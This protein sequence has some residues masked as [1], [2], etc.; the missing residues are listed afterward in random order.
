MIIAS[1]S[2]STLP[3]AGPDHLWGDAGIQ[4]LGPISLQGDVVGIFSDWND[5]PNLWVGQG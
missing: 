3:P 5:L 4:G 2:A 1:A